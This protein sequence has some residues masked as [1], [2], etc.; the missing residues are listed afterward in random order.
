[1]VL[2][3][4]TPYT[5]DRQNT[6]ESL[7]RTHSW[8]AECLKYHMDP[9]QLLFG[10]CQG[11]LHPD[12]RSQSAK[13]INELDFAGVAIGGVA[14][15]KN[16]QERYLAVTSAIEHI[17]RDKPRYVMGIG[18]P[19]EILDMVRL[20]IDCFDAAYPTIQAFENKVL[21]A[22]GILD[23]SKMK[24]ISLALEPIDESCVC[25]FCMNFTVSEINNL[26]ELNREEAIRLMS[27][28]NIYFMSNFMRKMR[29]AIRESHLDD[30][31]AEFTENW[32]SSN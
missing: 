27:Y 32:L 26:V 3:D 8:A 6:I 1:M 28:H 21:T 11:G 18:N 31:T 30:Y 9:K 10:I 25:P 19:L 5:S 20:G 15:I 2:D 17:T 24:S 7:Q 22:H 12:L 23:L 4:M 29:D 13:F 14:I 16:Q